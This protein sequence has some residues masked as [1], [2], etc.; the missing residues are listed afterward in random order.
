MVTLAEF[1]CRATPARAPQPRAPCRAAA[2][3]GLRRVRRGPGFP[4]LFVATLMVLIVAM[5]GVEQV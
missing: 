3:T 1:A 4:V 2:R 5:L